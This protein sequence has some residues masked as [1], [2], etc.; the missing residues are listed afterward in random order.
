MKKAKPKKRKTLTQDQK[1]QFAQDII[2]GK[3]LKQAMADW[4]ISS[5]YGYQIFNELLKWEAKW[6]YKEL[7]NG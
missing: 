7:E 1:R 4:N 6:K 3:M 2:N 5:V